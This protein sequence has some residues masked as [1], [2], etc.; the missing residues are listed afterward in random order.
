M[1]KIISLVVL[2]FAFAFLVG[3]A[4]DVDLTTEVVDINTMVIREDG[5]VQV[6]IVDVFDEDYY[7]MEEFKDFITNEIDQYNADHGEGSITFDIIEQKD[8]KVIV[9]IT[10][11]NIEHY[12]AFNS[13]SGQLVS[14]ATAKGGDS[15]LQS[16]LP[17]S[18]LDK[19]GETITS[20]QAL[21]KD[22]YK[23]LVINENTKIIVEGKILYY[24]NGD[25][26]DSSSL[27]SAEEETTF[28]IY[29]DPIF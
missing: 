8:K 23:V 21:K 13:T 18:F 6:A 7:E 9:V 5:K 27:Q 22:E 15:N 10:Y 20:A 14:A 29:K 12:S 17:E 3:C 24:S 2:T 11:S 4:K 16:K 26:I 28:I 19:K 1:K 25:Y